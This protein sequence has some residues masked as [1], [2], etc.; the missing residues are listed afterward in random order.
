MSQRSAVSNQHSEKSFP[1][2]LFTLWAA[3]LSYPDDMYANYLGRCCTFHRTYPAPPRATEMLSAYVGAS[4]DLSEDEL[5]EL[6]TRTFDINPVTSLEVGWHLFGEAYNRGAF[7]VKMRTLMEKHHLPEKSELPDHLVNMLMLLDHLP[8]R[9][10]SALAGKS[11]LPAL[12]TMLKGF[13]GVENPYAY[14]LRGVQALVESIGRCEENKTSG[15]NG[16][17]ARSEATKQSPP[18]LEIA[19]RSAAARN[20]AADCTTHCALAS[21]CAPEVRA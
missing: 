15:K 12:E 11:I 1:R 6:Y 2:G 13:E 19:S 10:A 9:D 7:L 21:V 14:L 16:V 18:S 8:P 17:I 4:I 20:D 3:V 5:Q